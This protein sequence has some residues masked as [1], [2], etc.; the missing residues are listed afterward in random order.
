[1]NEFVVTTKTA[2]QFFS[3]KTYIENNYQADSQFIDE[4][5]VLSNSLAMF[6]HFSI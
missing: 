3:E 2:T 5:F 1:M 6:S 4:R